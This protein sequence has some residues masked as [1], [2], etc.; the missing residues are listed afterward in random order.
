MSLGKQALMSWIM[1][2]FLGPVGDWFHVRTGA[3]GYPDGAYAFYFPGGVPWWVPLLFA[4]ATMTIG[5]SHTF[6]DELVRKHGP[7][8]AMKPLWGGTAR[9]GLTGMAPLIR[10]LLVFELAYIVSGYLPRPAGGAADLILGAVAVA[11]WLA[12]DRTVHGAVLALSTAAAGVFVEATLVA[13]G[14][15]HYG[16]ETSNLFGVASWLPWIYVCASFAA[17]NFS[18]WR[19]YGFEA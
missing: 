8:W 10:G 6:G 17:G 13:H 19:A 12:F 7:A 3:T 1:G 16:P 4:T 18:R 2:F 14:V 11:A 15:F 9:P 5:L